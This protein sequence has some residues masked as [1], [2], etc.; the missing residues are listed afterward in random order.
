MTGPDVGLRRDVFDEGDAEALVPT[1]VGDQGLVVSGWMES[2]TAEG[3]RGAHLALSP[4]RGGDARPLVVHVS[5]VPQ[6][7][8]ALAEVALRLTQLWERDGEQHWS[9]QAAPGGTGPQDPGPQPTELTVEQ[10]WEQD[11]A[12]RD[13][14]GAARRAAKAEVL[15]RV[16]AR[17][18]DVLAVFLAAEDD[19]AA[20][21]GLVPLLD[22]TQ[23]QAVELVTHLQL[24]ELTSA[25]RRQ[26]HQDG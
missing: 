23:E 21:D 13:E 19:A 11:A 10:V 24:R 20:A 3:G 8:A 18:H 26:L 22:V 6:L 16:H 5:R 9:G 14:A 1:G 15:D 25:A 2:H 17:A 4:F 12:R 7:V